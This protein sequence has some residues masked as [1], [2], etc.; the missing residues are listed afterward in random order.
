MLKNILPGVGVNV[1]SESFTFILDESDSN[2]ERQIADIV[3]STPHLVHAK[4]AS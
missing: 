3:V 2:I 4:S 1:S